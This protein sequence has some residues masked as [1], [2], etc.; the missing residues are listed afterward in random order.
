MKKKKR[1]T[2]FLNFRILLVSGFL[3][4]PAFSLYRF[5]VTFFLHALFYIVLQ[6]LYT[7]VIFVVK[8]KTKSTAYAFL[9]VE[10]EEKKKRC[11][12]TSHSSPVLWGYI[13]FHWGF[14]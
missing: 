5:G 9:E 7:K 8:T 4:L 13:S 14:C 1:G 6:H 11:I 3:P 12:T 2:H 10:E